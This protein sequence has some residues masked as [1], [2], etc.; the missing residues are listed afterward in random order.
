MRSIGVDGQTSTSIVPARS[1][2]SDLALPAVQTVF[3]SEKLLE[4]FLGDKASEATRDA[5]ERDIEAFGK[6]LGTDAAG[7]VGVLLG[8]TR[9]QAVALVRNWLTAM[10]APGSKVQ[11]ATQARRLSAVRSLT[12]AM[13]DVD[14]ISWSVRLKGPKVEKYRNTR[15][16]EEE[17]IHRLFAVCGE[18]LEGLRNR[19]LLAL[20]VTLALRRFELIGLLR[21]HYD[22][23]GKRMQVFGKGGT[24]TWMTLD[25]DTIEVLEAWLEQA[26]VSDPEAPL[27]HTLTPGKVGTP[28]TKDGLDYIVRRIGERAGVPV[29]PHALRHSA[30]TMAL[31]MGHDP[32]TVQKLSRHADI[33]T[34]FRYDDNLKDLG[35]KPSADLG[36]KFLR[37][38][39]G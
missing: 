8:C 7:A 31:D 11:T 3:D 15:G 30:I 21:K 6:H 19:L 17:A 33:R 1:V 38:P 24:E 12:Q 26:A 36:K 23:A 29:W 5:Y 27:V 16:P 9:G 20:L 2:R 10:R 34:L 35:S 28:I 32:R 25:A 13:Q 37:K 22:R 39:G 4:H 14:A 18:G